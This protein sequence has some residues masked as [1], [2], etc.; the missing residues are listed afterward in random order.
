MSIVL[1]PLAYCLPFV[2]LSKNIAPPPAI[3][4]R[5]LS[6]LCYSHRGGS[7]YATASWAS[8]MWEKLLYCWSTF[9]HY[10]APHS[11]A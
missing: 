1:L 4:A 10:L 9:R 8:G 5:P 6:H 2:A 3:T 7:E 11:Q